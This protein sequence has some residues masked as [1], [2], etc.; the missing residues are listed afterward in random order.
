MEVL[1]L[2]AVLWIVP[3]FVATSI[4]QSKGRAG[5]LYGVFLGWLGVLIVAILPPNLNPAAHRPCPHCKEQ[6]FREATVCPRCQRDV[7]PMP[8]AA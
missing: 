8:A 2:I 4:G 7:E 3:I 6:I 5:L 1:V